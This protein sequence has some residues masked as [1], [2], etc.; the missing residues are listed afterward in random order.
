MANGERVA[1]QGLARDVPL[2]IGK[3]AFQIDLFSILLQGCN[4][5]LGIAWLCTLGPI[6]CDFTTR[7]MAFHF[8][9][10]RVVWVGMGMPGTP[11]ASAANCMLA[12]ALFSDTGSEKDLLECLL[13]TYS[14]MFAA[15][16]VLPPAHACNHRIHL[17]TAAEPVAVRPYRYPQ[18]QK[19]ELE[20]Q[21][22]I[23]L[24][25][26]LIQLSTSPFSAPVLL[27]KKLDDTW[28][29]CVDYWALNAVTIKDKFPIPVVE[30]LLDELHGAR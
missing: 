15:P 14:D 19:D 27:V 11:P 23:M 6:L 17:K 4:I 18:I 26:G 10:H 30:E 12:S 16:K 2:Q 20:T 9:G 8:R 5:V 3:E 25:H 22:E 1:W 7:H 13:N 29:F 28:R 21:C 24:Q